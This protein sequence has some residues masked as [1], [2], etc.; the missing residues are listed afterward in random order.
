MIARIATLK[1][2]STMLACPPNGYANAGAGAERR[3]A[4]HSN[5]DATARR[6][7]GTFYHCS[8]NTLPITCATWLGCE[9]LIFG[10]CFLLPSFLPVS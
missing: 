9:L 7:I 2:G 8:R 6:I 4:P 1:Q 10:L 3:S 5:T